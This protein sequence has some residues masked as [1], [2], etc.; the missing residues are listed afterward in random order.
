MSD[1]YDV[2]LSFAGEQRDYVRVL[3]KA[4][5]AA[6]SMT[7]FFD[8]IVSGDARKITSSDRIWLATIA[9]WSNPFLV[10]TTKASP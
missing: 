3:A 9:T 6:H 8:T 1:V 5:V 10:G 7:V 2:A 4:L